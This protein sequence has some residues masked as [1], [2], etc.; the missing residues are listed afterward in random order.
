MLPQDSS[1]L[2]G[3]VLCGLKNEGQVQCI[4]YVAMV[5]GLLYI[6][7]C[8]GSHIYIHFS[9]LQYVKKA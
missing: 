5:L 9:A 8:T 6:A 4:T 2:E 3:L 7:S 1:S